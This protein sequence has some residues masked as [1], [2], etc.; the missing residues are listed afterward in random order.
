MAA[1]AVRAPDGVIVWHNSRAAELW[2]RTP[3]AGDAHERFGGAY[4]LYHPNGRY[5]AHCDTPVARA[6]YEGIT[7]QKEEV[8]IERPDGTRVSVWV[9][10]SPIRGSRG[11]IIGAVNFFRDISVIKDK[12]TERERLIEEL[13][14]FA[15]LQ[16]E[17]QLRLEQHLLE[18]QFVN[19]QM[20]EIEKE[21][22]CAQRE[23]EQLSREIV[24]T[25][26]DVRRRVAEEVHD[27]VG[28]YLGGIG[29]SLA[30]LR[31]CLPADAIESN[32]ILDDCS[33]LI[34]E[35]SREIRTV[36]HLSRPPMIDEIGIERA[37]N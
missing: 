10:I 12:A 1:Y 23:V 37:L 13:K 11:E 4:K 21:R 3:K 20:I 18:L 15:R 25:R 26:E 27:G 14:K 7:T 31:S 9:H 28:Q 36:A 32:G 16:W 33:A 34:R 17:S 6:L 22:Q 24:S 35:A 19:A 2:G 8:V 30:N 29:V 5:M